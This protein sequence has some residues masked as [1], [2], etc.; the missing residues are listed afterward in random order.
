MDGLLLLPSETL[1]QSK[2]G[3]DFHFPH[4]HPHRPLEVAKRSKLLTVPPAGG[5]RAAARARPNTGAPSPRAIN[6]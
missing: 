3:F 4:Q 1:S 5:A 2:T 6:N